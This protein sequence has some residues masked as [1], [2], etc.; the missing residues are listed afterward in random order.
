MNKRPLKLI[1]SDQA[2]PSSKPLCKGC[3][4]C[5]W[6]RTSLPGWLGGVDAETWL[7]YAHSETQVTCHTTG[8]QQCAGLA[9]YRSNVAKSVRPPLQKLPADREK[10]FATPKEF[11]Q[12]HAPERAENFMILPVRG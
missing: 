9:I 12:H 1:S 8:N 2:Q 4:D 6:T 7:S 10:V 11:M 5:P 3:S